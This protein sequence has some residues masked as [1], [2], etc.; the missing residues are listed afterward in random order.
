MTA[1]IWT[2]TEDF[3]RS[4]RPSAC[5]AHVERAL[6]LRFGHDYHALHRWSVD[7]PGA[8][9]RVVWDFTG[10]VGEGPLDPPVLDAN[11]LQ[12]ASATERPTSSASP[13]CGRRLTAT[14]TG[15]PLGGAVGPCRQKRCLFPT[16]PWT[17]WI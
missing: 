11:A 16:P 8:F 1:P 13:V 12:Q 6:G 5:S 14:T 7:D 10:M 17:R 4:H 3:I 9:W 15:D 2:P